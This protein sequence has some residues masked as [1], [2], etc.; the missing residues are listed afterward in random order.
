MA[1]PSNS[2]DASCTGSMRAAEELD[3]GVVEPPSASIARG[4][5][6]SSLRMGSTEYTR[7]LG[8]AL[9]REPEESGE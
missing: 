2:P 5:S 8:P 4:A 6:L 1:E 3:R 9:R 7:T